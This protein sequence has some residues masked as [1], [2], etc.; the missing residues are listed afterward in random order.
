MK[1]K[2]LEDI[3]NETSIGGDTPFNKVEELLNQATLPVKTVNWDE[4]GTEWKPYKE[5]P[6]R[7]VEKDIVSTDMSSESKQEELNI[8]RKDKDLEGIK[9]LAKEIRDLEEPK[10]EY[11]LHCPECNKNSLFVIPTK[12]TDKSKI[13]SYYKPTAALPEKLNVLIDHLGESERLTKWV[14][15]ERVNEILDYLAKDR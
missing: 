5:E 12:V 8:T 4:T 3:E 14:I 7:K 2:F 10:E 6:I 15:A 9:R 11:L 1:K 13:Q